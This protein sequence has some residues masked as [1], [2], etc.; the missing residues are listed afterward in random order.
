MRLSSDM[1][2][3]VVGG[4]EIRVDELLLEQVIR[5]CCLWDVIVCMS[6]LFLIVVQCVQL[7][8][9]CDNTG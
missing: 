7:V 9:E 1:A 4:V 6:F 8:H 5:W 3:L 2:V